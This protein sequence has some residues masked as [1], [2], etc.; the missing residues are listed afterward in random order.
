M[1]EELKRCSKCLR[2]LNLIDEFYSFKSKRGATLY[3]SHCKE[4][5]IWI[6]KRWI[7]KNIERCAIYKKRFRIKN[8]YVR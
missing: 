4:C 3:K 7:A 5:H 8:Q 6:V 1:T 2:L